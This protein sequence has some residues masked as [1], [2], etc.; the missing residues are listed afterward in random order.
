MNM[1]ALILLLVWTAC[2]SVADFP[3]LNNKWML[4]AKSVGRPLLP[5]FAHAGVH[6][7]LYFLTGWAVADLRAGL[8]AAAIQLPTHFAIDVWKGRM[9][10]WFPVFQDMSSR[11]HWWLFGFDQALHQTV[12]ILTV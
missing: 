4:D 1:T 11:W 12:K 8:V 6:T 9:G 7:V 3:P 10:V 2:H 5:I